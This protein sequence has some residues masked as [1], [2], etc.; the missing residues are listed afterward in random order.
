MNAPK[1]RVEQ[2]MLVTGNRFCNDYSEQK[3]LNLSQRL[4]ACSVIT[5]MVDLLVEYSGDIPRF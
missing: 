2:L 3:L 5:G 4:S 1:D